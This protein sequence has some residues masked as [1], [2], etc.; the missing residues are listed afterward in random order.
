MN[1]P[2]FFVP[3]FLP[4]PSSFPP[5]LSHLLL[6]GIQYVYAW[7]RW[8]MCLMCFRVI[9]GSQSPHA[10]SAILGNLWFLFHYHCLFSSYCDFCRQC[11]YLSVY[12]GGALTRLQGLGY[13]K[14]CLFW[15]HEISV[16][17]FIWHA[18]ALW[19]IGPAS[20]QHWCGREHMA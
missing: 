18:E 13:W 19:K 12:W 6:P 5:S 17:N 8:L 15:T 3:S 7:C 4:L 10:H 2:P 14:I 1:L 11:R 9:A 20:P 16:A